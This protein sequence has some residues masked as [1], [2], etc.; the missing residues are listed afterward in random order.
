MQYGAN[1]RLK[2]LAQ[3]Q[4]EINAARALQPLLTEKQK[5]LVASN[6][7]LQERA[8][9][10]AAIDPK[11]RSLKEAESEAQKALEEARKSAPS[12]PF[13]KETMVSLR[14][15]IKNF[16]RKMN[17]RLRR[18]QAYQ[19][20]YMQ[21]TKLELE[22]EKIEGLAV[23]SRAQ[24]PGGGFVDEVLNSNKMKWCSEQSVSSTDRFLE[25]SLLTMTGNPTSLGGGVFPSKPSPNLGEKIGLTLDAIHQSKSRSEFCALAKELK[26]LFPG[27]SIEEIADIA[28]DYQ[29]EDPIAGLLNKACKPLAIEDDFLDKYDAIVDSNKNSEVLLQEADKIL[30][31][32]NPVSLGFDARVLSHS[33]SQ[34]EGKPGSHAFTLVGKSYNCETK[35]E[36]YI[37]RNSWGPKSCDSDRENYRSVDKRSPE[38]LE[39]QLTYNQCIS[40]FFPNLN[41]GLGMAPPEKPPQSPSMGGLLDPNPTKEDPEESKRKM[42]GAAQCFSESRRKTIALNQPP[43]R[44][45][46]DGYYI[47]NAAALKE[48]AEDI[49]FYRNVPQNE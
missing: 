23:I 19:R 27:L 28:Q 12:D 32:G 45:T 38:L 9:E 47:I 8:G 36:E 15:E 14:D 20:L 7:R 49:T 10:F 40:R 13:Q 37:V 3:N 42:E 29:K 35:S 1:D 21:H 39:I 25:D 11:F 18:D 31:L 2:I 41:G 4:A 33:K 30:D 24:E 26:H 16:Q 43:F 46:E 22:R 44:C 6:L 17:S 34:R 5:E 48:T